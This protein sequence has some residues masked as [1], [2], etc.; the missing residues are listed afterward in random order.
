MNKKNV[1][2]A[3]GIEYKAGKINAPL[4]GW[5]APLLVDGNSKLGKGAWTW[6][7]L[8]GNM[9]FHVEIGGDVFET[10]G[11]CPCNCPGCYAQTGFYNMPSVKNANAV[12]TILSRMY[13][14]FVK[15]AIIAQIQADNIKLLRIHA[16]GDFFSAEYID[17]WKEIVKASGTTVFWTY[18][19]NKEA[20]NAFSGLDNINIVKSV[21]PGYGFNFGPCA[22]I[23]KVYK[24][25]K[26]IGKSVYIC[27]CGIDKNQ[28]CTNC[29]GC[30]K[31]EFVLFIEHST[32]YKAELD[33]LF[34]EVKAIIEAQND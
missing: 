23:L 16:S 10:L 2:A 20:E 17:A 7:M 15:R 11:T 32:S 12:K 5:I 19:K 1:Y 3:Y 22:Y 24:A 6:S 29:K 28:H 27:R 31:H 21:I 13:L 33:P 14:D 30:S 18:T 25:L 8:P 9:M 26:E 4:F 34:A